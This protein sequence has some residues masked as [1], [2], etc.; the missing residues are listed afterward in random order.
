M[1]VRQAAQRRIG[2]RN[3][4]HTTLPKIWVGIFLVRDVQV[5][6]M[7]IELILTVKIETRHPV[8]SYF[9]S[10]FRVICNHCVV[11]AA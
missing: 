6:E 5:K 9:G 4:G 8:E 7:I 1:S 10:E 3:I 2:L 11:M